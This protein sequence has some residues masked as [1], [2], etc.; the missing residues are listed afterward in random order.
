MPTSGGAITL[1]APS[2]AELYYLDAPVTLRTPLPS[3]DDNDYLRAL[4]A[5]LPRGRAWPRDIEATMT[6]LLQGLAPTLSDNDL[7]AKRLLV[8]SFP[9]TA[10]DLLPEWEAA[11]GLPGPAGLAS[12]GEGRQ[13][14][15]VAALTNTGGQSKAYFIDL[16]AKLGIAITITEYRPF[17]VNSPIG[18]PIQ[19]DLW[20]HTWQVNAPLASGVAYVSTADVVQATPGFGNPVLEYSLGRLKPAHTICVTSYT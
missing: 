2:G 17:T 5:L 10:V 7:A 6:K 9:A 14:E 16:A 11:L 4:Q 12:S 15:V 19:G 20:A 18:T 8:K 13:L 3:F 1:G